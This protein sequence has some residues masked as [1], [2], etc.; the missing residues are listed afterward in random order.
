MTPSHEDARDRAPDASHNHDAHE[1]LIQRVLHSLGPAADGGA[2]A[3]NI[4]FAQRLV[5]ALLELR[6]VHAHAAAEQDQPK[7]EDVQSKLGP[8][9]P[10]RGR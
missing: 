6:L 8:R 4:S 3:T 10:H 5:A 9:E 1:R 2:L 7:K